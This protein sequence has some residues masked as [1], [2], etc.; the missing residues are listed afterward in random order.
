MGKKYTGGDRV[1]SEKRGEREYPRHE[2]DERER[3]Y[4]EQSLAIN[5]GSVRCGGGR[6]VRRKSVEGDE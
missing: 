2:E 4:R 1:P 6:M 3:Q 5:A